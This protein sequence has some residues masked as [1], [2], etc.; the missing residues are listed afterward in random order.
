MIH[1]RL[2]SLVAASARLTAVGRLVIRYFN[3][4]ERKFGTDVSS[5][6]WM[7]FVSSS[8]YLAPQTA[9]LKIAT[10]AIAGAPPNLHRSN[11]IP[12]FFGRRYF[13]VNFLVRKL[14]LVEDLQTTAPVFDCLEN[15]FL[16]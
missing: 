2:S 8:T 10:I 1:T 4:P 7:L 11:G 6:G 14:E 9:R 12:G 3:F 15:H 13:Q 16:N 5:C